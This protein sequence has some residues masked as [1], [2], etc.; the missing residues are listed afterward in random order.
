MPIYNPRTHNNQ[1]THKR[2]YNNQRTYNHNNNDYQELGSI[3]KYIVLTVII[4]TLLILFWWIL[5]PLAII[6]AIYMFTKKN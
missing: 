1:R 6:L 2:T 4:L 5:I 3:I